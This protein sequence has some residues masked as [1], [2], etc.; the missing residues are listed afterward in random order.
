MLFWLILCTYRLVERIS[1]TLHLV[2]FWWV[3]NVVLSVN[4][5]FIG[6]QRV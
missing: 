6:Y 4:V 5:L 2:L 1:L 3:Q